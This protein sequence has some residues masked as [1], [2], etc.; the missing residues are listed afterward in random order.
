MVWVGCTV[1]AIQRTT[2]NEIEIQLREALFERVA[3][4][5]REQ[6]DSNKRILSRPA[7]TSRVRQRPVATPD[8]FCELILHKMID[9][10]VAFDGL[11]FDSTSKTRSVKSKRVSTAIDH[12]LP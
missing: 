12:G 4:Q 10:N 7:H 2:A 11:R 5:P 9:F 1:D 6:E 8:I 3:R